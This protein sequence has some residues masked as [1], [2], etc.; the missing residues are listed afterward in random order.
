MP[1]SVPVGGMRM[2]VSTT[3]GALSVTDVISD[4]RS[5]AVATTSMPSASASN[6]DTPSRTR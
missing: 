1:S 3:S 2:S 5:V 4:P 6:D